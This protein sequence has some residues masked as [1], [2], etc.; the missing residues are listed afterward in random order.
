MVPAALG[1]YFSPA[2]YTWGRRGLG[3]RG[4]AGARRIAFGS[5]VLLFTGVPKAILVPGQM[6]VSSSRGVFCS[7]RSK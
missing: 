6:A 3:A 1:G 5:V 2:N 4:H 7:G